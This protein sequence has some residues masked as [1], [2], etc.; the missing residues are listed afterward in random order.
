MMLSSTRTWE[1]ITCVRRAEGGG[2]WGYDGLLLRYDCQKCCR[3]FETLLVKVACG[4]A[5][6]AQHEAGLRGLVM[7]LVK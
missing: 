1:I 6:K 7:H 4:S 3:G 5:N 2:L